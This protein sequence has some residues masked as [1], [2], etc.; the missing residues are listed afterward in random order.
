MLFIFESGR[1]PVES[2]GLME[3][4]MVDDALSYEYSG[5]LLAVNKWGSWI[6]QYLLGSVL[7][8]V[9]LIPWGLQTGIFGSLADIPI[10]I[11]KW[12][13]L[14][15]ILVIIESSLAKM[16]LFKIQDYLSIAF[17]ISLFFLILNLVIA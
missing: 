13:I 9:F 17:S 11:L 8:N 15:V 10:M 5:K 4:G 12:I 2:S 3:F 1:L 16:R 14:I 6:K 7:I